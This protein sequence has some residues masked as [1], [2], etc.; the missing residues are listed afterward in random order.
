MK[1][2]VL[3]ICDLLSKNSTCWHILLFW[4]YMPFEINW[5]KNACYINNCM[6]VLIVS[7]NSEGRLEQ[8][9]L[10]YQRI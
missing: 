5:I 7:V 6:H 2:I 4:R 1:S 10:I 3:K 8:N 9:Y